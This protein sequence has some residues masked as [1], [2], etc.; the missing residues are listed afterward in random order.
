GDS[1]TG[2]DQPAQSSSFVFY[3]GGSHD[4]HRKRR[5]Q[6]VQSLHSRS[7]SDVKGNRGTQDY[8]TKVEEEEQAVKDFFEESQGALVLYRGILR[9]IAE[10]WTSL[11]Q[12]V[13]IGN[14]SE[15]RV[16]IAVVFHWVPSHKGFLPNELVDSAAARLR[17]YS[18]ADLGKRLRDISSGGP[19]V[20]ALTEKE[21][22]LK[23]KIQDTG[24]CL[25]LDFHALLHQEEEQKRTAAASGATIDALENAKQ[26]ARDK[27]ASSAFPMAKE[28]WDWRNGMA[29][30]QFFYGIVRHCSGEDF[31]AN[32]V[33]RMLFRQLQQQ[34]HQKALKFVAERRS[35]D[36]GAEAAA[37]GALPKD[38]SVRAAEAASSDAIKEGSGD[39]SSSSSGVETPGAYE[40]T[41][42]GDIVIEGKAVDA[43][44][45]LEDSSA[46][47][48]E[49]LEQRRADAVA[50]LERLLDKFRHLDIMS[51][52]VREEE[53]P[54][55]LSETK[56]EYII[57]PGEIPDV[58]DDKIAQHGTTLQWQRDFIE[59]TLLRPLLDKLKTTY[60][61]VKKDTLLESPTLA[62]VEAQIETLTAFRKDVESLIVI[63]QNFRK[64]SKRGLTH[65]DV[66]EYAEIVHRAYSR[67]QELEGEQDKKDEASGALNQ[68]QRWP[69]NKVLA[70]VCTFAEGILLVAAQ[71]FPTE[72]ADTE[73]R[74]NMAARLARGSFDQN[75]LSWLVKEKRV[76]V[77]DKECSGVE[78]RLFRAIRDVL[79]WVQRDVI[80]D[81]LLRHRSIDR[82]YED[83]GEE[84][85]LADPKDPARTIMGGKW[86]DDD[87]D[88][89]AKH[90]REM[91]AIIGSSDFDLVVD[92]AERFLAAGA[93]TVETPLPLPP[94]HVDRMLKQL[95]NNISAKIDEKEREALMTR[96]VE[97]YENSR[98]ALELALKSIEDGPAT[99]QERPEPSYKVFLKMLS[100]SRVKIER[101][102]TERG[103]R[104]E[105]IDGF[106]TSLQTP[107]DHFTF[108]PLLTTLL[109]YRIVDLHTLSSFWMET[110]VLDDLAHQLEEDSGAASSGQASSVASMQ[111]KDQ[112]QAKDVETPPRIFSGDPLEDAAHAADLVA[113]AEVEKLVGEFES[114]LPE[115]KAREDGSPSEKSRA[116]EGAVDGT[117]EYIIFPGEIPDV[118][119]QKLEDHLHNLKT[120]RVYIAKE[121]FR[122]VLE[123]VRQNILHMTPEKVGTRKQAHQ[124]DPHL[125]RLR[126]DVEM[127]HKQSQKFRDI[128]KRGLAYHDVRQF[129]GLLLDVLMIREKSLGGGL[130][131][132]I[133]LQESLATV[134]D[135]LEG[136]LLI[137]AQTFSAGEVVEKLEPSAR[138]EDRVRSWWVKNK[139]TALNRDYGVE[140]RLFRGIK[141]VLGDIQRD[142]IFHDLDRYSIDR[143]ADECIKTIVL[144]EDSA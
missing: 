22:Q 30:L 68:R 138:T 23:E 7:P 120:E 37:E 116:P 129:A 49:D 108:R 35:V 107:D 87:K 44:R 96:V 43:P 89:A 94:P 124:R 5:H 74:S 81:D 18:S 2:D 105:E 142:M 133:S 4:Q 40:V 9:A 42:T 19:Q 115:E 135:L 78:A 137:E 122:P 50:E 86:V 8:N 136:I 3:H 106:L 128:S 102:K 111:K 33:G 58:P 84:Q 112:E 110:R 24:A 34:Q 25:D 53:R 38:S 99:V 47:S 61:N 101:L 93:G 92:F 29:S 114:N 91:L 14:D 104:Q 65:A 39:E 126:D 52:N 88:G 56:L 21:Q 98:Y 77:M 66:R 31:T 131:D 130:R 97:R 55:T 73:L 28:V 13:N 125:A 70:R 46:R 71:I 141:E 79:K 119:E 6:L 63:L 117:V 143:L 41:F 59:K 127:A 103:R 15:K 75:K 134:R 11:F 17:A 51:V 121:L 83:I 144:T 90:F 76:D 20:E 85:V 10:E 64:I 140:A 1:A 100:S 62:E 80:F 36:G 26:T 113:L 139:A 57:V 60:K 72:E 69:I 54:S 32:A 12:G 123:Q 95:Q 16:R 45:F 82:L 132:G 27:L 48:R 109:M 118:P 67:V